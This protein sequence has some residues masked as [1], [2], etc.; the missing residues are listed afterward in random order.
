MVSDEKIVKIPII[1]KIKEI[2]S[3]KN[4]NKIPPIDNIMPIKIIIFIEFNLIYCFFISL[5]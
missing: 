3:L 5:F 4:D 2:E 1:T